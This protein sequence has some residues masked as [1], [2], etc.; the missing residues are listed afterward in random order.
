[1]RKQARLMDTPRMARGEKLL[2]AG[3]FLALALIFFWVFP[4][5]ARHRAEHTASHAAA[6]MRDKQK[7]PTR[8]LPKSDS[9]HRAHVH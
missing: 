8:P 7:M 6:G 4:M 3:F 5:L 2:V 9:M 1:M